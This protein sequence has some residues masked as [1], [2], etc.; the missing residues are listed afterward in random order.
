M[1]GMVI[2]FLAQGALADEPVYGS[3]PH[4]LDAA[5]RAYAGVTLK[6]AGAIPQITR[7]RPRPGL[8]IPTPPFSLAGLAEGRKMAPTMVEQWRTCLAQEIDPG[9]R[10]QWLGQLLHPVPGALPGHRYTEPGSE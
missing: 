3:A 7:L 5:I 10:T 8:E 1:A 9:L 6:E 2:A 4:R